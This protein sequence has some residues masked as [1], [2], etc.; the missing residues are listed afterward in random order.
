MAIR[1]NARST[2]LLVV[3]LVSLSLA[4]ITVDY[5]QGEDGPLSG[6]G[7]EA[8]G[9][10]AP[11]QKAVSSVT[12][13]IGDF[14]TGIAEAP[15]LRRE[16]TAL[17]NELDVL[18]REFAEQSSVEAR[19]A[20]LL[21][22]VKLAERFD[23]KPVLAAVIAASPSNFEWTITI[24]KGV[25]DGVREDMPVIASRGLVGHVLSVSDGSAE[26]QLII[27]RDSY[28]F[29]RLTSGETG[30]LQGQGESD[31]LMDG[32]SPDVALQVGETEEIVETAGYKVGD[33]DSL[34]PPHIPIG[35]V[36]HA[37]LDDAG[38]E[39][40]VTVRPAVD[41]SALQVVAV[42]QTDGAG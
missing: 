33:L 3:I 37:A 7:R 2:R 42:L 39:T 24:D 1:T 6:L 9:L 23:P 13:P 31:L 28:V 17:Q 29:S 38:L 11:L 27:D 5:R 26:V 18:R 35:T 36:S 20:E 16:N 14:F 19:Y 21:A 41:F 4:M 32:V 34:Y 22:E 40:V 30:L 25:D 12:R 10:M 8:L 15:A